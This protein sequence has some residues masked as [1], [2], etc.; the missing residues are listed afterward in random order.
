[1][2]TRS[3]W[4]GASVLL[5]AS[6][7]RM[8][9]E[10]VHRDDSV[11]PSTPEALPALLDAS[12]SALEE[13]L[14]REAPLGPDEKIDPNRAPEAELDRIPGVG[15]ATARAIVEQRIRGG[16]FRAPEELL[17]VR[18][19]GEKTLERIRDRLDFTGGIPPDLARRPRP[20]SAAVPMVSDRG[21]NS[22]RGQPNLKD[23]GDLKRVR[24]SGPR[25]DVNSAS[26]SDLVTLPGIGP[27]LAGRIVERRKAR[28][29]YR[30][31]RD[32][33]EIRGIGE[34]TL[35]RISALIVVGKLIP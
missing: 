5:L 32:L 3:L 26:V 20:S 22:A 1:M 11:L 34:Q 27:A 35:E 23:D 7:V 33:L 19:I 8:G 25:L 21:L 18:G 2:E 14:R 15:P 17:G 31:P 30:T 10:L 24:G 13:K 6:V 16:G 12:Q 4:A 9:V 29:P 28:G